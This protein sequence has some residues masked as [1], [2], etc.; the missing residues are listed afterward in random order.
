MKDNIKSDVTS[1]Y[2]KI[3][4]DTTERLE[5]YK[6]SI[7]GL[8]KKSRRFWAIEGIKEALFWCMCIAILL[9]SGRAMFDIYGVTLPVLVWQIAYPC[10]FI[11]LVAY[12]IQIAKKSK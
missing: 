12:A 10:T 1:I 5:K 6:A 2:N 4:K 9:L 3:H 8:E 7:D 11:P